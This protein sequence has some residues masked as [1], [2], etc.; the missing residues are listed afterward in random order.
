MGL[1]F[2]ILVYKCFLMRFLI[3]GESHGQKILGSQCNIFVFVN[4]IIK[5]QRKRKKIF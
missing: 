3:F 4:S 2:C 1:Q 5:R